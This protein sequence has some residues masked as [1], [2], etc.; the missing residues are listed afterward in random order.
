MLKVKGKQWAVLFIICIAVSLAINIITYLSGNVFNEYT[1]MITI[2]D[3]ENVFDS[4]VWRLSDVFRNYNFVS[5]NGDMVITMSEESEEKEGYTLYEDFFYSPVVLAFY[6]GVNSYS[7]GFTYST[8]SSSVPYYLSLK[9]VLYGIY[10]EKEWSDLQISNKIASGPITLIIPNEGS[11]EYEAVV[12]SMY[13]AVENSGMTEEEVDLFIEEVLGKCTSVYDISSYMLEADKYT[14]YLAVEK[15]I[16]YNSIYKNSVYT[17][18]IYTEVSEY[19]SYDLYVQN[20]TDIVF[21]QNEID[22]T[23]AEYI[24]NILRKEKIF[25][26]YS[27]FRVSNSNYLMRDISYNL[28]ENV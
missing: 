28:S 11:V 20:S 25:V 13:K 22:Y 3:N 14:V 5:D 10:E 18:P 4:S 12:N 15:D 8:T 9:D 2:E 1:G 19:L 6:H 16:L 27:G 21:T 26:K 7:S 17:L 24:V 23:E